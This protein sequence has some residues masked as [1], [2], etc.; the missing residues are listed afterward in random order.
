MYK[1]LS[2]DVGIKNLAYCILNKENDKYT[3]DKWDIINLVSTDIKCEIESCKKPPKFIQSTNNIN[4]YYCGVHK[5]KYQEPSDDWYESLFL[6]DKEH[7][8]TYKKKSG[9]LCD[10]KNSCKTKSD[11]YCN[12]HKKTYLENLKKSNKLVS[13][14]KKNCMKCTPYE[15]SNTM[16]K[17]LDA[18]PELL[19]VNEVLIENQP[20]LKNPTIKSVSLFLYSYFML[21][22]IMDKTTTKSIID[23]INFI[24]PSNKLKVNNDQTLETLTKTA[25]DKK[26]KM[27]KTLAEQYT[28][29]L[30][31]K[32]IKWTNHLISYKKKD[33]LCDAYLQG[34]YY[35]YN[36]LDGCKTKSNKTKTVKKDT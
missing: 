32:D 21:R 23:K 4:K 7:R 33:D 29:I 36:K 19:Q 18:I 26:Y 1:V 11:Y 14:K 12:A 30:L 6:D 22:G 31:N 9:E 17:K 10:K 13:V 2:W 15:L 25:D 3:I 20:T 5:S 24:S 35:M 28:K 8:C 34:Y 16:Y 27:T